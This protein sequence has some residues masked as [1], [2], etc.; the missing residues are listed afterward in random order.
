MSLIVV[1]CGCVWLFV[2]GCCCVSVVCLLFVVCCWLLV[3]DLAWYC[4]LLVVGGGCGVVV[5]CARL[6][7]W[8]FVGVWC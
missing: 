3:V 2:D 7:C 6:L 8:V 1:V 5:G 4:L